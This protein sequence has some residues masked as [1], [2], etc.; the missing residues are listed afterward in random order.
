VALAVVRL[1]GALTTAQVKQGRALR[2]PLEA[3]TVMTVLAVVVVV[4]V[5][6]DKLMQVALL[7]VATE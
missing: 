7:L 2:V 1:E 3:I 4:R 6:L 5:K